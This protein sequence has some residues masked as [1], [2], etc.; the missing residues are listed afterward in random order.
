LQSLELLGALA[1]KPGRWKGE[2]HMCVRPASRRHGLVIAAPHDAFEFST[3]DIAQLAAEEL[4]SGAVVAR[5]YRVMSGERWLNVNRPTEGGNG[6]RNAPSERDTTQ[7]QEVFRSYVTCLRLAAG[8]GDPSF[9]VEVHGTTRKARVGGRNEPVPVVEVVASGLDEREQRRAGRT[10]QER[11][12]A[13]GGVP[14]LEF[15]FLELCKNS[16]YFCTELGVRLPFRYRCDLTRSIG[17]FQRD[18]VPR[19]LHLE[20]PWSVRANEAAARAFATILAEVTA[21]LT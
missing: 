17:S 6:A 12:S 21:G 3:G 4:G 7:A 13:M 8:A 2:P 19:G 10:F 15:Q 16:D 9:L 11:W 5:A 1:P 14:A 20:L 18:C